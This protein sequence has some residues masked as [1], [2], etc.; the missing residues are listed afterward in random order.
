MNRRKEQPF[1]RAPKIIEATKDVIAFAAACILF[2]L[3]VLAFM[4]AMAI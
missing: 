4:E 3:V 2:V 1:G